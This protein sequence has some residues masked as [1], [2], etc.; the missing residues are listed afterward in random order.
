M[1]VD[2][3]ETFLNAAGACAMSMLANGIYIE[4]ELPA[5]AF[6]DGLQARTEHLCACLFATEADIRKEIEELE[7]ALTALSGDES[8][9]RVKILRIRKWLSEPIVEMHELVQELRAASDNDE[10]YALA[11]ILI[12]ES[13]ANILYAYNAAADVLEKEGGQ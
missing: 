5:V 12:E 2:A 7:D 1:N 6:P 8:I 4:K 3:I 13:A 10:R 11:T 9:Q